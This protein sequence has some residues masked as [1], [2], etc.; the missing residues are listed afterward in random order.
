MTANLNS[1]DY[2]ECR[3]YLHAWQHYRWLK[4]TGKVRKSRRKLEIL[5]HELTCLRCEAIRIDKFNPRSHELIG[6]AYRYPEGYLQPGSGF[7]K[8]DYVSTL[9]DDGMKKAKAVTIGEVN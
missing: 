5:V 4:Y 6:R 1:Y 7:V 8:S 2:I 9:L 3:S